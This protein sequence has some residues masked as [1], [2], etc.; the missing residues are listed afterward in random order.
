[1]GQSNLVE[2]VMKQRTE[3]P[4]GSRR[5]Y[6]N[7]ILVFLSLSLLCELRNVCFLHHRSFGKWWWIIGNGGNVWAGWHMR[8]SHGTL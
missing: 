3:V 8:T 7:H 1:M 5:D 2:E 6:N 4:H